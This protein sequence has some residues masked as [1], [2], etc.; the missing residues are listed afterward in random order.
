[1]SILLIVKIV[2]AIIRNVAKLY[3]RT[4][5]ADAEMTERNHA[6]RGNKNT[7]SGTQLRMIPGHFNYI[8]CVLRGVEERGILQ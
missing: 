8:L 5:Q 4:R 2:V 1:M 7:P 6:Q 3:K